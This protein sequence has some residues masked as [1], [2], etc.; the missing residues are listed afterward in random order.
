MS[1]AIAEALREADKVFRGKVFRCIDRLLGSCLC[2]YSF[3]I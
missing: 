2:W 1:D 3:G